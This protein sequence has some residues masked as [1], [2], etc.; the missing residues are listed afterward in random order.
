MTA[1]PYVPRSV[2]P[3]D[4]AMC[5]WMV[6]W[7]RVSTH[8]RWTSR[9]NG[10][11]GAGDGRPETGDIGSTYEVFCCHAHHPPLTTA[12]YPPDGMVQQPT[13]LVSPT[14]H[15]RHFSW[16]LAIRSW[17]EHH[18]IAQERND[19]VRT[20]ARCQR[21]AFVREVGRSARRVSPTGRNGPFV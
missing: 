6:V 7:Y 14:L 16:D 18:P 9:W 17:D 20:G 13:L 8:E 5:I 15:G 21:C 10:G 12:R 3:V 2:V 19:T 11:R 1:P 4:E